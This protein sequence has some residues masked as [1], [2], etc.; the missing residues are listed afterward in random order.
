MRIFMS[1]PRCCSPSPRTRGEGWGEG[2]ARTC[3]SRAS[4]GRP[5]TLPSPRVR[6][7]GKSLRA[8]PFLPVTF[9]CTPKVTRRYDAFIMPVRTFGFIPIG[10]ALLV[11]AT[12]VAQIVSPTTV[13]TKP[14]AMP[15][16]VLLKI[17]QND[18]GPKYDPTHADALIRAHA[19][20]EDYFAKPTERKAITQQL[21][22]TNIDPNLLGRL[23][24]IRM[25]W[26]LLAGGV[27]YINERFGPY[28]VRYFLGIP[29]NYDRSR[30]WPLVVKLPAA[31]PFVKD[32]KPT[33]DEVAVYYRDWMG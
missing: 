33:A 27:Y 22:S 25:N 8:L 9:A 19:L 6:G 20:I 10:I 31:D 24:R 12:G 29:S 21:E 11:A 2:S 15:R 30:P 18:L 26:P 4:N 7:E 14:V 5:L 16:D 13:S 3:V 17:Y 28:T 23:A 1:W 32:P